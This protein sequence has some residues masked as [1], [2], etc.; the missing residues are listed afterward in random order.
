MRISQPCLSR[1]AMGTSD[2]VDPTLTPGGPPLSAG[3]PPLTS[4]RHPTLLILW[5]ALLTSSSLCAQ[6]IPDTAATASKQYDPFGPEQ[7][8]SHTGAGSGGVLTPG[9]YDDLAQTYFTM[10]SSD[11]YGIRYMLDS[12]VQIAAG[13]VWADGNVKGWGG[14][15]KVRG[16]GWRLTEYD[17]LRLQHVPYYRLSYEGAID[18]SFRDREVRALKLRTHWL[19]EAKG[20]SMSGVGMLISTWNLLVGI[21]RTLDRRLEIELTGIQA[22]GGYVMPLSPRTGGANLALC[23]TAELGGV[24]YQTFYSGIGTY[25]G[26]KLGTL[27]WTVSGGVN[28]GKIMNLAFYL[29]GDWSFALGGLSDRKV[30]LALVRRPTFFLALQAIGRMMNVTAGVQWEWEQMDYAGITKAES[31]TRVYAGLNVYFRR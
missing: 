11:Y 9:P 8:A 12:P 3:I 28:A 22:S 19:T 29:G 13:A 25:L 4:R 2:H 18:Y 21:E 7:S 26:F 16:A 10:I 15:L 30:M 20:L 17:P 6:D 1:Q 14:S 27:G 31:A 5:G 23:F 24:R